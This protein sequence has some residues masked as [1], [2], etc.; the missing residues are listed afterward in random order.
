MYNIP[1]PSPQTLSPP[2]YK[3]AHWEFGIA[4]QCWNFLTIYGG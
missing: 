4:V 3:N 1:S 2:V